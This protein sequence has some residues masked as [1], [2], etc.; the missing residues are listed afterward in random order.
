[1]S[2][3]SNLNALPAH[4][5]GAVEKAMKAQYPAPG[6]L[7]V[8][9][10]P[11]AKA[12]KFRNQRCELDGEVFDSKGEMQRWLELLEMQGRGEIRDLKRQVKFPLLVGDELLGSYVAD[13]TYQEKVAL[14]NER[15]LDLLHA[16]AD[17]ATGETWSKVVED[18]KGMPTPLYRWKAKHMRAQYRVT[19]RE[20]GTKKK[21]PYM[22]GKRK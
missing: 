12:S 19:I 11:A 2:R 5:R 7:P 22:K 4:M 9:E 10:A 8:V 13:F 17:V 14:H 21:T 3:Y 20:T 16:Q 1:M 6:S 18:W 15:Q